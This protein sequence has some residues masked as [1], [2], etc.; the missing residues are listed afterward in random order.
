MLRTRRFFLSLFLSFLLAATALCAVPAFAAENN[1]RASGECGANGNNLTWTLTNDG[2]LTVSGSGP[3]KDYDKTEVSFLGK[4][5]APWYEYRSGIGR[6]VLEEG[7]TS[8]GEY[9]FYVFPNPLTVQLPQSLNLIG[10]HAFDTDGAVNAVYYM[11]PIG[12]FG[13]I[14]VQSNNERLLSAP[15][16]SHVSG[17]GTSTTQQQNL[18][19]ATCTAAG[20]Y[21]TTERCNYCQLV[22]GVTH[23]TLPPLG[24]LSGSPVTENEVPATAQSTGRYDRVYYCTRCGA[25]LF[26]STVT[27]PATGGSAPAA[28]SIA[29]PFAGLTAFHADPTGQCDFVLPLPADP[30]YDNYAAAEAAEHVPNGGVS[31][32]YSLNNAVFDQDG[33]QMAVAQTTL[34]IFQ[35]YSGCYVEVSQQGNLSVR[36]GFGN[37]SNVGGA[38]FNIVQTYGSLTQTTSV[39]IEQTRKQ[40]YMQ[41]EFRDADGRR[42]LTYEYGELYIEQNPKV[43]KASPYGSSWLSLVSPYFTHTVSPNGYDMYTVNQTGILPVYPPKAPDAANHY[44]FDHWATDALLTGTNQPLDLDTID[45]WIYSYRPN[46]QR[47]V[48]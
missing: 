16:H 32:S 12:R 35:Y 38:C 24:H 9:A 13:S 46:Y 17:G 15:R 27:I 34:N 8:V 14:N 20:G 18:T 40:D 47:A 44:E 21:D 45:S 33:N 42:F 5:R 22:L 23:T 29:N 41:F 3:M 4:E 19:Q 25:E 1:V 10:E 31:A 39:R 26:R 43:L 28:T 48:F 36:F 6:I 11:A 37:G 30:F 7:V 2:V